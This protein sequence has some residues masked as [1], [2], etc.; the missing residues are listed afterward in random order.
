VRL[1]ADEMLGKLARWLRLAGFDVEYARDASDGAILERA[2][3]DGRVLLTRDEQLAGRAA[4]DSFFV[5]SLDP[6]VQLSEVVHGLAL[7]LDPA[8][9][10]TRCTSCNGTLVAASV[11][12]ARPHVPPAVARAK[13]SFWRC[14]SCGQH[15][16][17][18]T[19]AQRIRAHLRSIETRA[20]PRAP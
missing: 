13:D 20:P 10:L 11:D 19:H 7:P 12:E 18:G 6:D 16:W 15:Y 3:S 1:L 8:R 2:R 5:R 4:P 14:A 9:Y 17:E